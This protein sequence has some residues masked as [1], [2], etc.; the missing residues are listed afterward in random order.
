MLHSANDVSAKDQKEEK[1]TVIVAPEQ[2]G[3]IAINSA[4]VAMFVIII[5]S[6]I[7]FT[8]PL[9]TLNLTVIHVVMMFPIAFLLI[10]GYYL[11]IN[12][13]RHYQVEPM[14]KNIAYT[15]NTVTKSIE[16]IDMAFK[17]IDAQ[18]DLMKEFLKQNM[19]STGKTEVGTFNQKLQ[20]ST[21]QIKQ[22][23]ETA[24]ALKESRQKL[25]E[26][27]RQLL[28]LQGRLQD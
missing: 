21:E 27:R 15:T 25:E 20:A 3:L 16:A 5:F 2:P 26:R 10:V 19:L 12:A 9:W 8:S 7:S 17:S 28:S 13:G 14:K 24:K 1:P 4:V 6:S 22:L 23:F 11:K 18:A